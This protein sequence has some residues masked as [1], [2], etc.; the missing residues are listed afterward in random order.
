ML[1]YGIYFPITFTFIAGIC[2]PFFIKNGHLGFHNSELIY[3]TIGSFIAIY[4]GF[5]ASVK[6]W[7]KNVWK[8]RNKK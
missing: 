4:G 8:K 3:P 1:K 5:F 2:Y 6:W 7:H